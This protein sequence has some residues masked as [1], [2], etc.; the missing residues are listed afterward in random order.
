LKTRCRLAEPA[1]FDI[2]EQSA[3]FGRCQHRFSQRS[4]RLGELTGV[5]SAELAV[6][7]L[8]DIAGSLDKVNGRQAVAGRQPGRLADPIMTSIAHLTKKLA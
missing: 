2:G 7:G 8:E 4:R 1:A 6:P 3:P 5:A